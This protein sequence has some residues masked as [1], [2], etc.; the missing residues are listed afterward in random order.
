M[1]LLEKKQGGNEFVAN[2]S[3]FGIYTRK[4]KEILFE[5]YLITSQKYLYT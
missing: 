1:L 3:S 4:T 2:E 5:N